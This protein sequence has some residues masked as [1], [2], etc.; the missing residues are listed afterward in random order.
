MAAADAAPARPRVRLVLYSGKSDYK[1]EM[2]HDEYSIECE[3]GDAFA[4][5]KN[6]WYAIGLEVD[7]Q[8]QR[9]QKGENVCMRVSGVQRLE[10]FHCIAPCQLL[11]AL[12]S[13][14]AT[15]ICPQ[16]CDE[17]DP[18]EGARILKKQTSTMVWKDGLHYFNALEWRQVGVYRVV[19]KITNHRR[20]L[21]DD[22]PTL[23]YTV[24]VIDPEWEAELAGACAPWRAGRSGCMCCT[25]TTGT[26]P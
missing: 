15:R 8:L 6:E 24:R 21:L 5:A 17:R 12:H 22:V 18:D 7:G 4:F 3:D 25:C 14:P 1:L 16:I 9:F 10:V 19:F 20:S 26:A 2:I 13:P 23:S 11:L